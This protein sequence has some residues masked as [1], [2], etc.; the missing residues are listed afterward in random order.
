M[1]NVLG[2]KTN[3]GIR[4]L[5]ALIKGLEIGLNIQ[6]K[7]WKIIGKNVWEPWNWLNYTKDRGAYS[8]QHRPTAKKLNLCAEFSHA[9]HFHNS[10][11]C[12]QRLL[13]GLNMMGGRVGADGERNPFKAIRGNLSLDSIVCPVGMAFSRLGRQSVAHYI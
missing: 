9:E 12:L 8:L 6:E 10:V 4:L 5:I 2:V 13:A 1:A 11:K 7:S 3:V